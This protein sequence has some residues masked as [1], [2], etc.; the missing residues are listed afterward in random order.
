MGNNIKKG[1]P[2]DSTI[3]REKARSL[4]NHYQEEQGGEGSSYESSTQ[5]F[6]ASKGWFEGFKRFSLRN[7]KVIGDAASADQEAAAVFPEE[8]RRIIEE[9]GYVPEQVFNAYESG[10]YWKR[11]PNRSYVTQEEKRLP[12]FKA[13]KD[14][15]TRLLCAN[16]A[17]DMIKPGM[18]YHSPNPGALKGKNQK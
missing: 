12:G 15:V 16:A 17:G 14:R 18:L 5:A 7:L 2:I 4:Y 8:F 11:I 1:L 3:L 9:K 10:L 6:T 13:S